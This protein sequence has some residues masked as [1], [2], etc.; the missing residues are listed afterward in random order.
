MKLLVVAVCAVL[1]CM[2]WI[3]ADG[4]EP[5]GMRASTQM[6]VVTTADWDAVA[7]TLQR[8]ERAN[9]HKKWKKAGL[10]FPVVVAKKGLGWGT[11]VAAARDFG[12]RGPSGT[13]KHEGDARAPVGLFWLSPAFGYAAE[14][15]AGWKMPYVS[16][17]PTVECVPFPSSNS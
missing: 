10:P 8:Y 5:A 11:G 6:L 9:A 14:P 16:L 2:A 7:G 1:F 4:E 17:T 13:G 15:M 3:A 12:M